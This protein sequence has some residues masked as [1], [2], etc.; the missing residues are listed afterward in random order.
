MCGG[1]LP[2][3]GAP[4]RVPRPGRPL[5]VRARAS[6]RTEPAPPRRRRTGVR[7]KRFVALAVVIM[8]VAGC[9]DPH[10]AGSPEA[11]PW[12]RTFLSV[13]V[14][15]DGHPRDLVAGTRIVL[16]FDDGRLRADAGCNSLTGPV[17]DD[18]GRLIVAT[19][20][21]TLIGCDQERHEQDA[22]LS[23]LLTQA[24][25]WEL[26]GD[27]LVMRT[28]TVEVRLLD[29]RVADPDR[30]LVGTRWRLESLLDGE[31]VSSVPADIEA[32]LIFDGDRFEGSTG[33]NQVSG[34][35]I[36]SPGRLRFSDVS[37][38]DMWCGDVAMRLESAVL[39][40]LN[41]EVTVRITADV[42]NLAHPSGRGL[43]LGAS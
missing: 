35:A 9:A 24:P 31:A 20:D 28:E 7:F 32:Y 16:S 10:S 13:A 1:V 2:L 17:G 33:C 6:R 34:A 25:R 27:E 30:P 21:S 23:D 14:T 8:A 26:V 41:G 22:W 29:R 5:P 39:A 36:Q 11:L 3:A 4:P 38:T 12:G 40:V 43:Q 19:M 15:E 37:H 42:L 18:A